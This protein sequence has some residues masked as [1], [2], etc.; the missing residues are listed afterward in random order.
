MTICHTFFC[1]LLEWNLLLKQRS[2][3]AL[4][5]VMLPDSTTVNCGASYAGHAQFLLTETGIQMAEI[6]WGCLTTDTGIL[7][8]YLKWKPWILA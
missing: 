7:A 8:Q 4:M 5:V 2:Y 3:A 1:Y 6:F